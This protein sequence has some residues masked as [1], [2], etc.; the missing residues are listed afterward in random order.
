MLVYVMFCWRG[1]LKMFWGWVWFVIISFG[2][3]WYN[4]FGYD[5]FV[6]FLR[7]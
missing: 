7:C 3:V 5:F 4:G 1:I 2:L 6:N